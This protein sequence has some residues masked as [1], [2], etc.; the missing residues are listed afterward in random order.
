[1]GSGIGSGGRQ[2]GVQE[3]LD[4]EAVEE[5]QVGVQEVNTVA[6]RRHAASD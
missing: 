2:V 5:G 3:V 4:E 1:M 6:N